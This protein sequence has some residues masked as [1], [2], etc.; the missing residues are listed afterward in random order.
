MKKLLSLVFALVL[1]LSLTVP[2]FAAGTAETASKSSVGVILN[3]KSVTFPDAKPELKSGRTMVP[4]STLMTALGGQASYSEGG[5]ITCTVGDTALSFTLGQKTVTA[6]ANG[7]TETIQMDVPCYYKGG[8][9]YVPV[10][11][12]AQ[13][14]G[15]DVLWDSTSRSAVLVDKSA[16]IDEIDKN[17]TVLNAALQKVQSDP[18]KNYKSTATYDIAMNLND[19]TL[20]AIS[21][22]LK[23]NL[24]MISS[25][26]TVDMKGTV[27]ASGLAKVLDLAGAVTNGTLSAAQAAALSKSLSS[28]TF[29]MIMNL[30]QD[31]IYIKMPL[32]NTLLGTGSATTETWYQ[33]SLG[34]KSLGL[35]LTAL[36]SSSSVGNVVYAL[37]RWVS[38]QTSAANL[39]SNVQTTGAAL[40]AVLGD[41]AAKKSGSSYTWTLDKAA[42]DQ[43][44]KD[45]GDSDSA[46]QF[47]KFTVTL[48]AAADGTLTYAM[49]IQTAAAAEGV[50]FGMSG[51]AVMTATTAK[52]VMKL[53]MGSAGSAT[54]NLSMTMNPTSE[55]PSTQPPDGAAIVSLD[56][57]LGGSAL[58]ASQ[59]ATGSAA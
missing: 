38:G 51:S 13:A 16:L 1:A 45:A 22:N 30:D 46:S 26:T 21:V 28:L 29:E 47:Q 54:Y 4:C 6:T 41:S 56:A 17:F 20:G 3:G 43:L 57:L 53:D 52:V 9:T 19:D 31:A 36:K 39:S 32:I 12:F 8:R 37:C 10:S 58:A 49:D 27:D 24:T 2:A 23:M 15:Y 55:T 40:A 35:N 18:T 44:A 25:G 33:I 48:T 42:F 5:V 11:F 34:M 7:K 50:S 14:L 59:G